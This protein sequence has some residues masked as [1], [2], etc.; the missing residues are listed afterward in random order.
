[1][2]FDQDQSIRVGRPGCYRST[3]NNS[4]ALF[5]KLSWEYFWFLSQS[6]GFFSLR[7]YNGSACIACKC[8]PF[9]CFIQVDI[10]C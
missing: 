7:R 9:G 8:Y 10:I 5:A 3:I 2:V 1:M 6:D 4:L